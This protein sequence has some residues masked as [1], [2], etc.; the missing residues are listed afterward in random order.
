MDGVSFSVYSS[1]DE[2]ESLLASAIPEATIPSLPDTAETVALVEI[3]ALGGIPP[4]S[5]FF[6]PGVQPAEEAIGDGCEV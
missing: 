3:L 4:D 6:V 1:I 2:A 5:G